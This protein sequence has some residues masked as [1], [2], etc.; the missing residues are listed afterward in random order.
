MRDKL[1]WK[2]LR[3]GPIIPIASSERRRKSTTFW[4]NIIRYPTNGA[5]I[6]SD[7]TRDWPSARSA[8]HLGGNRIA[9]QFGTLKLRK[10][11]TARFRLK[12]LPASVLASGPALSAAG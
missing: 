12:R 8:S 5:S 4:L 9:F 10:E 11:T 7:K 3:S 1:S 6:V 2:A